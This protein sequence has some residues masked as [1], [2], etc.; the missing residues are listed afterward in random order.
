M[1][2]KGRQM[3]SQTRQAQRS[4]VF[5]NKPGHKLRRMTP[6]R[7]SRGSDLERRGQL[8]ACDDLKEWHDLKA[9][10]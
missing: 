6:L 1:L 3:Q 4:A 2:T 7:K 5:E 10:A 9:H 8:S